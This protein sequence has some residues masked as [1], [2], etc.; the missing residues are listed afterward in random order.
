MKSLYAFLI[1]AR[2]TCLTL[3]IQAQNVTP[4]L[5]APGI[6]SG[7]VND[8]APVFTPDG[9]T[10]YFHRSGPSLGCFI[11]VSHWQDGEWSKPAV[12]PFSGQWQDLEPA[13]APD[14]SYMI[15]SSNRPATPG[16]LPLNGV[17]SGQHFPGR[18]GN[19][20]RIDR[21]GDSWSEPHR[22]PDII[23]NDSSIFSPAIT[24][25]GSLYFMKPAADTGRFHLYYSTYRNGQYEQPVP[26]SFSA[27]DSV[28]D[29][30]PAVAADG[31]FLVFS[32]GRSKIKGQL[33][34]VFRE[35]GQ[36]GTPVNMGEEVNRSTFNNE[37]KLSPDHRRL[38]FAST[39]AP[40]ATYPT[41]PA[42]INRKL[43]ACDW[44]TGAT[45]IWSVPLDQWLHN[46]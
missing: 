17:W 28:S 42:T 19:F 33:F 18:G 25:D 7:P 3:C 43:A 26:V 35:N 36:W 38:Y 45:N 40:T 27:P 39:Y 21:Q 20:W 32:S 12:A 10:V 14:G 23:N 13:M 5:F 31:S 4:E 24:A 41:D 15:F 46:R 2:M 44:D 11:F 8:A 9:R 22:L 34:I 29:V 30:D 1:I 6:I 16:G 37:A